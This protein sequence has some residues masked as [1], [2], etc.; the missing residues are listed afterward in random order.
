MPNSSFSML[1]I[2]LMLMV[3]Y[4]LALKVDASVM[5]VSSDKPRTIIVRQ[6][7]PR[8]RDAPGLAPNLIHD[9]Q[10]TRGQSRQQ[11]DYT[12]EDKEVLLSDS[13]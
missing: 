6:E 7:R 12:T 11:Q 13:Y 8:E 3:I 4:F 9:L 2:N 5:A 1:I 10:F